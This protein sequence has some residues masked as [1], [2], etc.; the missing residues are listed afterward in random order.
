MLPEKW[1][2][3]RERYGVGGWVRLEH[4]GPC[5]ARMMIDDQCF[6]EIQSNC[7]DPKVRMRDCDAAGVTMQVLSTV[8]VMFSYGAKPEHALDLSKMLNDHLA[9]VVSNYPDRFLALGTIPLQAPDLAIR[10][11]ERCVRH[12]KMPGVQIGSNVNGANLDDPALFPIFE[13]AAG[14]GAAVFV[15]PW[16]MLARD[17]MQKYWLQWLVGMPAETCLAIC[18]VIFGGV[19]TRLPNL[20]LCFAHGGGSFPGTI[21]RIDHGCAVRPD[22]CAIDNKTSPREH[23]AHNGKPAK[24]WVDSLVH[25]PEALRALVR[26]MGDRRICL[27]SDYPFPLGEH[28]PGAL[29]ES[30][31]DFSAETRGRLLA[32]NA[33]EFLGV[34]ARVRA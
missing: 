26:L 13:A 30:M 5:S 25:D 23:V 21:G 18:S 9:A 4:C 19:L 24:F 29:I 20:R 27:G 34:T 17:R 8:P 11:L 6:R 12:L 1:P 15:H 31:S 7:W 2:D 3:L 16:Q 14:L 22:L 10:E 33:Q 32:A 28:E